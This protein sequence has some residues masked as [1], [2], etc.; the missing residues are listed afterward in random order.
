M[1]AQL[2]SAEIQ[3]TCL[4]LLYFRVH[5]RGT[6]AYI[7][8]LGK[9]LKIGYKIKISQVLG[10]HGSETSRHSNKGSFT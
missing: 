7:R 6:N 4:Y 9:C 2:N 8:Y 1:C 5:K 10:L 3:T